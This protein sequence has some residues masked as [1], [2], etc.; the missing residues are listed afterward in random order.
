M[1]YQKQNEA[2]YYISEVRGELYYDLYAF[3]QMVRTPEAVQGAINFNINALQLRP[4]SAD[5]HTIV[6][7]ELDFRGNKRNDALDR[8]IEA[9]QNYFTRIG[10]E[11]VLEENPLRLK[12]GRV[13]IG[14]LM[15]IINDREFQM[16]RNAQ[17]YANW[18]VDTLN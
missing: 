5:E 16:I 17:L 13:Q 8:I 4:L 14:D 12:I 11:A 9:M 6:E 18:R 1:I 2:H 7:L 3:Q 15:N 10:L